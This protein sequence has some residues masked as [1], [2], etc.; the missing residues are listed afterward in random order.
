M[1][2]LGGVAPLDLDGVDVVLPALLL[3]RIDE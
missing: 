3:N 1:G 2:L